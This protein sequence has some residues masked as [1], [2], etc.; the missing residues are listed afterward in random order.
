MEEDERERD[1]IVK[2]NAKY[3]TEGW[4]GRRRV[5]KMGRRGD[6][7]REGG[8]QGCRCTLNSRDDGEGSFIFQ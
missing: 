3:R 7:R 8:R 5:R 2:Q 1:E 4:R 6:E